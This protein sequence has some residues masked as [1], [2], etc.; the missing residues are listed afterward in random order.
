LYENDVEPER[1]PDFPTEPRL[2][3]SPLE[4]TSDAV[5][6]VS[7]DVCTTET[8]DSALEEASAIT[9]DEAELDVSKDAPELEEASEADTTAFDEAELVL[10]KDAPVFEE[11][12]ENDAIPF[13]EVEI[14]FSKD[15][16]LFEDA[17][18]DDVIPFE[19]AVLALSKD[20][21]VFEE[22]SEVNTT[23]F[24]EAEP[25]LSKDVPVLAE[26]SEDDTKT[27]DEADFV[28]SKDV[29]A[30]AEASEVDSTAFVVAD[31]VFSGVDADSVFRKKNVFVAA[32][33]NDGVS[34]GRTSGF[35]PESGVCE[36]VG[37]V[38]FPDGSVVAS[39]FWPA[40]KSVSSSLLSSAYIGIV[41]KRKRTAQTTRHLI[42]S[43]REM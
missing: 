27:F 16:P 13:D 8:G 42:A 1:V 23:S 14:A 6:S 43:W 2:T 30:L 38:G 4:N 5:D 39:L 29:P 24:G 26:A 21:S 25:D 32:L 40:S 41:Q 12:Y 22:T 20:A 35:T 11:A 17:S 3:G 7:D 19:E 28:L 36:A 33:S 10:S 37:C 34:T 15:P 31:C 18:E 9:F